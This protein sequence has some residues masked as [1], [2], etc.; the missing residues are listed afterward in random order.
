[1]ELPNRTQRTRTGYADCE[2]ATGEANRTDPV[3]RVLD[4]VRYRDRPSARRRFV[5]RSGPLDELGAADRP[6]VPTV[7][8]RGEARFLSESG[9]AATGALD[10]VVGDV[11]DLGTLERPAHA[12]PELVGQADE[13]S[14]KR[15]RGGRSTHRRPDSQRARVNA[16]G[17]IRAGRPEAENQDQREASGPEQAE[18]AESQQERSWPHRSELPQPRLQ[19]EA[20]ECHDET[21]PRDHV[22]IGECFGI[23]E[24][25]SAHERQS[26]EADE[27]HGEGFAQASPGGLRR[28]GGL[29]S[30]TVPGPGDYQ[31]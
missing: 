24:P 13:G 10:R 26:Q 7:C 5:G 20:R 18:R 16:A 23:H 17:D 19:S 21:R 27:E 2:H 3:C 9:H 4:R 29:I 8:K 11:V 30:T 28:D 15:R 25:G 14:R 1:M 22:D 31:K 6:R 12:L